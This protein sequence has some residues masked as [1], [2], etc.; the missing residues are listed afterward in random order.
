MCSSDLDSMKYI[1]SVSAIFFALL[2]RITVSAQSPGFFAPNG[3]A[4]QW[5]SSG[6]LVD[7]FNAL[8]KGGQPIEYDPQQFHEQPSAAHRTASSSCDCWQ[9]RDTSWRIAPFSG[10]TAPN[11]RNDDGSTPLITLPFSFCFYGQQVNQVFINNNGNVSIGAAYGTFSAQGFP[12]PS[13][14]MI[15]PFW[16]DVDTRGKIGRAHV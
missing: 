12:N 7:Y 10:Y 14:S 13:Y 6:N 4:D 9:A 15:A 8:P 1:H 2:L 16:A 3:Q 5:K 11:Y